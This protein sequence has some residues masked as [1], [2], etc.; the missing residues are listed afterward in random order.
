M[1]LVTTASKLGMDALPTGCGSSSTG[2]SVLPTYR[3]DSKAAAE[4]MMP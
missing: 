3:D 4:C 2:L 1:Q